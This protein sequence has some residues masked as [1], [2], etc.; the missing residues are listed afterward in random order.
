LKNLLKH[1]DSPYLKQHSDN[2]VHWMPWGKKSLKKAKQSKKPIFLSI[3]YSSCHWCHVMEEE[4]F[5]NENVAKILNKYFISIK[6]DKEERP[7]LDQYYQKVYRLLQKKSGGWPLSIFM[8]HDKK[9]F[10]AATYI[11]LH[12]KYGASHGFLDIL[13]IIS[14]KYKTNFDTLNKSAN[15]IEKVTSKIDINQNIKTIPQNIITI[16]KKSIELE[17]DTDYGGFSDAPKFPKT[18]TLNALITISKLGEDIGDMLD[19]TLFMMTT[20]G[21]YDLVDG[22]FCRYS[23]DRKWLVPHFEKMAYDNGLLLEVFIRAFYL[24]KKQRY[25]IF[26]NHIIEFLRQKMMYKELFYSASDAD[27]KDGEGEYFVYTYKE[28]KKALLKEIPKDSVDLVLAYLNITEDGSFNPEYGESKN[29][30]RYEEKV[31]FRYYKK[32]IRILKGI[33]NSR[34]YPFIDTKIITSWNSMII[35]ALFKISKNKKAQEELAIKSLNKLILVM[36]KNN[37]LYHSTIANKHPKI[38]AYL[39][40]YAYLISALLEANQTTL[41]NRYLV[42]ANKLAQDAIK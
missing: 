7:D 30:V 13:T 22:G 29:I 23:T 41:D 28:A 34:E 17:Y 25:L 24:T 37:I 26:A 12:P 19:N 6:V 16:Y 33:R 9:P 42:L 8:T 5:E 14:N 4:S 31:E 3:G 2:P 1:E 32:A 36:Y 15:E 20:G 11:P 38:E 10:Y 27:S 21:L 40:D 18:A 39:E 35:K